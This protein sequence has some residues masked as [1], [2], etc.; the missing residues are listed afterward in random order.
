[1]IR[2]GCSMSDI[3]VNLVFE[4]SLSGSVLL[5]LLK[6]S[7]RR[8]LVGTSY[9]SGGYGWIKKRIDGF[10]R[11][12]KGMPYLILTDL[13]RT[14][15]PPALVREWRI[16]NRNHNLLFNIAVKQVESWVLGCRSCFAG[17]LGITEDKIP[18]DVDD[19]PDAKRFLIDLA[20]QSRRRELR[21][22]IVPAKGSTARVGRDYN[23]RLI[24]FV[25]NLW[26]PNIAKSSSPSLRRTMEVLD[27]FQPVF[28]DQS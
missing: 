13:D 15:C 10:N 26:D 16:E 14:E 17:F 27:A 21:V 24:Y 20:R 28:E 12:A 3:P 7:Q 4:D 6:N 22:D 1:M 19:I 11:A 9:N 2:D 18:C 8:Y 23:G 5:R 25:E